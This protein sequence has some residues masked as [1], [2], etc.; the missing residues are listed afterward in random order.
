MMRGCPTTLSIDI[1]PLRWNIYVCYLDA[2]HA[3]PC[4]VFIDGKLTPLTIGKLGAMRLNNE[5]TAQQLKRIIELYERKSN[6]EN[7]PGTGPTESPNT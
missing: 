3:G 6:I 5:I 7:G 2:D 4:C 1:T